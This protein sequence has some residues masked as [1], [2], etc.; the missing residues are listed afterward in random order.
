M[1]IY[2][3]VF[4]GRV[5]ALCHSIHQN[6]FQRHQLFKQNNKLG[7]VSDDF[8]LLL[9]IVFLFI[10]WNQETIKVWTVKS[11]NEITEEKPKPYVFT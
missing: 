9:L 3:W 6:K 1:L 10:S 5:R 11:D 8:F 7:K 4:V 2:L